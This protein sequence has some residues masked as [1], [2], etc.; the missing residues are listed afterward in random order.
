MI[1]LD[2]GVLE[3]GIEA[4]R[5]ALR[6]GVLSVNI[7]DRS[8]GL[9]LVDWQGNPTAVALLTQ[10]IAEFDEALADTGLDV[11]K[12]YFYLDLQDNKSLILINHGDDVAQGWLL[13]SSKTNPGILLG[14]A[15]PKAIANVN[16]AKLDTAAKVDNSSASEQ[17]NLILAASKMGLWD[18]VI[19]PSD[20]TGKHNAFTWTPEFRAMLGFK[21]ENDFPNVLE[22]W[23]NRLHPDH[24]DKTLEAFEAHMTDKSGKT[25]Y[26]VEYLLQLKNGDYRW[27]KATGETTRAE[28]GTPLRVVGVLKDIHDERVKSGDDEWRNYAK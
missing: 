26:D 10:M 27:Y 4:T 9:P 8:T 7:W 2:F 19:D 14:M 23:S 1:D 20:P 6:G 13:D 5:T 28:D 18:M 24:H 12:D 3:A 22:S 21:D 25:P 16:S 17:L 15:V 11:I